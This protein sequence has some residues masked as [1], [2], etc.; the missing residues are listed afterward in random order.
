MILLFFQKIWR[1]F[2]GFKI[3]TSIIIQVL[4]F[5]LLSAQNFP[6]VYNVRE[7]GAKGD[8]TTINTTFIQ[9]AIDICNKKGGGTIY[10]PAG[11]Y[12]TGTLFLQDN[13]TLLLDNGA[14]ILGS[15]DI[16]DYPLKTPAFR[17]YTDVNYV[18]KSLI[19][20]EG[21]KNITIGGNGILNGQGGADAFQ[22]P[23]GGAHYKDRPYMIRMIECQN[24]KIKD[25]TIKDSPMWVQHYLACKDITIEGIRVTSVV[26]HNN[27]GI[28]IDCCENVRISNCSIYSGDDAIVLKSTAPK[29]CKNIT[30]NNCVLSSNCNA[31]KCGTESTGALELVDGGKFN[32]VIASNITMNNV[33][34]GIFIR[35][36]NRARPYLSKGPGGSTGTFEADSNMTIPP[37]GSLKNVKI[38]NVIAKGVSNIGCSITGIPNHPVE[39]ISL[40]NINI[41][42]QGGGTADLIDKKVPE[43]ETGYPEHKMF[44]ILPAY[45]FFCR[46][47]KNLTFININLYYDKPDIRYGLVC[48]DVQDLNINNFE[49]ELTNLTPAMISFKNIKGAFLHHS[50]FSQ[51]V[52][53]FLEIDRS[54]ENITI[55]G[56][57]F[58]KV[59]GV[60]VGDTSRFDERIFLLNNRTK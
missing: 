24:I 36:G 56:N 44:G 14:I 27:D 48:E 17:S 38:N 1:H 58:F 43:N 41:E 59:K 11:K 31:F 55:L 30:I 13:I 49:A 2:K 37:V 34:G 29:I 18:N 47:V 6:G 45:G 40:E 46:H 9:N 19:Y 7:Y 25:I 15:T 28:D 10:F 50:S 52:N 12:L 20:A 32:R 35:L 5:S 39:N 4:N 42:F 51:E 60:V 57:N 16:T 33:L 54:S 23:S 8:S 3:L 26:N 53:A 22:F 21:K